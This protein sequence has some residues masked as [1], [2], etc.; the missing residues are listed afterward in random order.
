MMLWENSVPQMV[1]SRLSLLH[2]L[3]GIMIHTIMRFLWQRMRH[4]AG[5]V[6]SIT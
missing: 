4:T 5:A 6:L 1:I 2:S 3:G